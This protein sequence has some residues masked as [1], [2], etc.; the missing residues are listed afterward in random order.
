MQ[1]WVRLGG[2]ATAAP[3]WCTW[4]R[5][6]HMMQPTP[7]TKKFQGEGR[8]VIGV[9]GFDK[10]TTCM[11]FAVPDQTRIGLSNYE[12]ISLHSFCVRWSS[13]SS[14]TRAMPWQCHGNTIAMAWPCT[15]IVINSMAMSWMQTFHVINE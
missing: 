13:S 3:R 1:S 7:T 12:D 14:Y 8:L 15:A 11:D 5:G 2:F 9:R 10:T 4:R 6:E